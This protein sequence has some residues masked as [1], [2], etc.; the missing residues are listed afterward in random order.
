MCAAA[1]PSSHEERMPDRR[2]RRLPIA[3]AAL[4]LLLSAPGLA[5]AQAPQEPALVPSAAEAPAAP[6]PEPVRGPRQDAVRAGVQLP[7]TAADVD[8]EAPRRGGPGFGQA[9]ALMI[10]GGAGVVVGLIVGGG[11][12]GALALGSAVVGLVGLYQYLR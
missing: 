8:A 5:A 9:E 1:D 4:A 11:A 2:P 12:G 6:A 10:V 7:A 3:R